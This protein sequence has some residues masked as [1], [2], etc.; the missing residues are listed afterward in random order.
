MFAIEV[1]T[2]KDNRWIAGIFGIFQDEATMR[3]N[4]ARYPLQFPP[5]GISMLVY[6]ARDV[7]QYPVFAIYDERDSKFRFP[8]FVDK[9]SLYHALAG[10]ERDLAF[11]AQQDDEHDAVY[12]M[13]Y[14]YDNDW[15]S[16]AGN[17]DVNPGGWPTHF[18]LAGDDLANLEETIKKMMS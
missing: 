14:R 12:A 6:N 18:H 16:S 11:E 5:E 17:W 7:V 15:L 8:Q 1:I 9:D 4:L 10:I 2:K 3:E 13:V